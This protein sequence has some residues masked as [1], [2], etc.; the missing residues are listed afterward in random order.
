MTI[1]INL[2]NYLLYNQFGGKNN[3][4]AK[5]ETFSHNGVLFPEPYNFHGIPLIYDNKKIV[6]KPESEEYATIYAKFTETEYIKNKTFNKNFFNDWIKILKSNGHTEIID[7]N[8]CDFSLIL[9]YLLEHKE[10][11]KNLSKEEKE[12]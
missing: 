3:N 6:L 8:K 10:I 5:W 7:L 9:K 4:E 1:N 12:I 2:F 11:K